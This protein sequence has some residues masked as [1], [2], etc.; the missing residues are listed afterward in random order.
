VDKSLRFWDVRKLDTFVSELN[1]H[2]YAVRRVRFSPHSPNV[3]A[4][5][6]YDMT[7]VV[8]DVTV[9]DP[10]IAVRSHHTEFVVGVE[11]GLFN[12][13]LASC[14]WDSKVALWPQPSATK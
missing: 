8:W 14:G 13:C 2:R 6:S 7:V 11:W 4:S 3:L 1:G 5:A 12:D 10:V 9:P